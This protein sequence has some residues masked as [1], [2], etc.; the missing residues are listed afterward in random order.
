MVEVVYRRGRTADIPLL[1]RHHRA[2]FAE[3]RGRAGLSL[4]GNCCGPAGCGQK[5]DFERL[6]EAQAEKLRE[7][8]GDNTCV[9]WLAEVAG[10][11]VA[12]GC[13]SVMRATP[14]PEDPACRVGFLH[15]LFVEKELRG[16]GIGGRLVELLLDEGR[17][18]GLQRIQLAASADGRHLYEKMGFV[19]LDH[20]VK[21]L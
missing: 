8:F 20:M 18:L 17:D 7:Q 2:M 9:A 14:V 19:A 1:A 16:Q 10:N 3:M 21:W 11:P 4:Q 12:S 15:S 6:Q 13:L 5:P